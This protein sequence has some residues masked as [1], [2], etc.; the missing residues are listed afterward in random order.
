MDDTARAWN[1]KKSMDTLMQGDSESNLDIGKSAYTMLIGLR[2]TVVYCTPL[3]KSAGS[4]TWSATLEV[5]HAVS[6]VLMQTVPELWK[7][8][9]GYKEGKYRRVSTLCSSKG[10]QH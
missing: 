10:H 8:C 4:A 5:V 2:L 9:R 7:I 6:G 3:A 1:L